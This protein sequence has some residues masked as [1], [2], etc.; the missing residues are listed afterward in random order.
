MQV[1]Q[2]VKAKPGHPRGGDVE[3]GEGGQA[4]KIV[5]VN[6]EDPNHVIVEWDLDQVQEA[7]EVDQL[8]ALSHI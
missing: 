7:V 4:G 5:D 1:W 2:S 8:T 6:P 3:K